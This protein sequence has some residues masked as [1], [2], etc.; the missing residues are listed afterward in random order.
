MERRNF[1]RLSIAG[2][3]SVGASSLFSAWQT[4]AQTVGPLR[5]AP[6]TPFAVGV[7]QYNWT[8]GSRQ[9]TTYVYYPA[10]GTAG[11]DSGPKAM[12][13][14]HS[15]GHG[16]CPKHEKTTWHVAAPVFH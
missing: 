12:S 9:I 11:G 7:R 16:H 1:L 13:R 6:T 4:S 5:T 14:P 8:R 15:H 2:A 3:A 10:T